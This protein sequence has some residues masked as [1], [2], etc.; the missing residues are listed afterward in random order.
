MSKKHKGK[1]LSTLPKGSVI[2]TSSL[3]RSAQLA[4]NMPHLKVENIRGNL[5]T[6]LKKL[7]DESGPFAA[8][9]LAAAGLKRM[10][11]EDRISQVI[12]I[13]TSVRNCYS[14]LAFLFTY[15]LIC[16]VVRTGGSIIRCRARRIRSRVSRIRLE[17]IV[18]IRTTVRCR[19]N[20]K[21]CV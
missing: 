6:R 12:S 13:T 7:D 2:G 11:W 9:I 17:N 14:V 10:N 19:Y 3:R 4:R 21:M 20:F 1:T 16:V 15:F 8:I 18:S 5:N